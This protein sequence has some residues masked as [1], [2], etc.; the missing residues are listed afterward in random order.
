MLERLAANLRG[1]QGGLGTEIEGLGAPG[2]HATIVLDDNCSV[3]LRIIDI[4]DIT[5]MRFKPGY[6]IN[7]HAGV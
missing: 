4:R 1:Q 2:E 7:E 6:V 5:L 3:C